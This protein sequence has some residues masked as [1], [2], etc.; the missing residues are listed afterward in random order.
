MWESLPV[1]SSDYMERGEQAEFDDGR[2]SPKVEG[3][4][5]WSTG[6]QFSTQIRQRIRLLDQAGDCMV[7]DIVGRS[8]ICR[9]IDVQAGTALVP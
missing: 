2:F 9:E 8:A 5:W 4:G 7:F 6:W 3:E 1:V